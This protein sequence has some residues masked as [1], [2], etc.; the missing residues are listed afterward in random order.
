[1]HGR[2]V[3]DPVGYYDITKYGGTDTV[4]VYLLTAEQVDDEW[5]EQM[6]S[7]RQWTSPEVAARLLD[8]RRVSLVFNQAVARLRRGRKPSEQEKTT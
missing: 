1:M 6:V 5:D 7:Q 2:V 8:G 3:G 4:A